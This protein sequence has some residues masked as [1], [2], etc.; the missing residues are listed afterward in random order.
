MIYKLA[1]ALALVVTGAWAVSKPGWDSICATLAAL[2]ALAACFTS[3][4]EFG[5]SQN[6]G[7][8]GIGVQAGRDAKVRDITNKN[9]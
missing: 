3:R 4:T 6:V 1:A 7:A 2:A 5:Q 8:G 9:S